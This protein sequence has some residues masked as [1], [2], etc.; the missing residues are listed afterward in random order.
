MNVLIRIVLDASSIKGGAPGRTR[1]LDIYE[2]DPCSEGLEVIN[3]L[4]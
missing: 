1:G 4:S 3:K 2:V